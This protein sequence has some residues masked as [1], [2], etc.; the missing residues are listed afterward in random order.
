MH[1]NIVAPPILDDLAVG[2]VML[3][4]FGGTQNRNIKY[5]IENPKFE[6]LEKL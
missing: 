4:P 3:H 1:N 2:G 6:K 5:K